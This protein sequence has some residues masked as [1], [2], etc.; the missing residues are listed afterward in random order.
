MSGS[1]S[2]NTKEAHLAVLGNSKQ[3]GDVNLYG[4]LPDYDDSQSYD[5]RQEDISR[6][7]AQRIY[8]NPHKHSRRTLNRHLFLAR[9]PK[10]LS[11]W[12]KSIA[13]NDK[14]AISNRKECFAEWLK[15]QLRLLSTS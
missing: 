5:L 12:V 9:V 10:K 2:G 13:G 11:R 3:Q 15:S 14:R 1:G 4:Q 8:A 7:V 6:Q